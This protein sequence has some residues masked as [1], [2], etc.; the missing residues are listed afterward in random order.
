VTDFFPLSQNFE[1]LLQE[2][3]LE[4]FQRT[5]ARVLACSPEEIAPF[6]AT[7][8]PEARLMIQFLSEIQLTP[9]SR[10]LEVGCGLG[11]ASVFLGSQGHHV[12][13]LDPGVGEWYLYPRIARLLNEELGAK[14]RFESIPLEE[15]KVVGEEGFDLIFSNNVLEHVPNAV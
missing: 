14:I 7:A 2:V 3:D 11:I 6:F 8:V 9:N 13:A 10:I 4:K 15:F 5:A 12:V 1:R